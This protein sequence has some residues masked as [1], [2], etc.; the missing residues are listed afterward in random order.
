MSDERVFTNTNIEH[1]GVRIFRGYDDGKWY[2]G[3]ILPHDHPE[4]GDRHDGDV[5]I[6]DGDDEGPFET[7]A[8]ALA[9]ALHFE[10]NEKT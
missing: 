6:V 7:R 4:H 3:C 10:L 5:E 9:A 2:W 8:A 1:F